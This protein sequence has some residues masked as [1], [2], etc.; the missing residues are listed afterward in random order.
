MMDAAK[1]HLTAEESIVLTAA[2]ISFFANGEKLNPEESA[3][4]VIL[5]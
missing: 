2:G 1:S 3:D 4:D 5:A